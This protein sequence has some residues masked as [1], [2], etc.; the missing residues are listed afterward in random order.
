MTAMTL[1]ALAG[2][3]AIG[4][5]CWVMMPE[6]HA[7]ARTTL[8]GLVIALSLASVV[9]GMRLARRVLH[10]LADVSQ[11]AR[12]MAAGDLTVRAQ[13]ASNDEIGKL[14]EAANG[15]NQSLHAM[16]TQ[17][18]AK[19]AKLAVASEELSSVSYQMSSTAEET[20]S[21][22]SAV[23][24]GAEQVSRSVETAAGAVEEMGMSILEISKSTSEAARVASLAAQEAENTNHTV[25]K[26]GAS[27][28]EIGNVVKV[29]NSIAQQTNLLALNATIEAARAGEAG[30][31]FAVVANEVKDLAKGTAAATTDIS[32]KIEMIQADTREAI[33][34]IGQISQT[35]QQIKDISNTI[36][37]AIDE[38]LT[39]T[40][41]IGRNLGEAARG[42]S[43]IT[44]GIQ[45]VAQAARDTAAGSG[46]TQ[47]AAGELAR[48]AGDLR[49]LT[50]RFRL[51]LSH[52]RRGR[53]MHEPRWDADAA[54]DN[55]QEAA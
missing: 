17:L 19:G 5:I 51:D 6:G 15:L 39:T 12:A 40:A 24:V 20:S 49:H 34:A 41:E 38:Q 8:V 44:M 47:K 43:E 31:G 37:S 10:A 35:I 54:D 7:A 13:V 18:G 45:N 23:S 26:L 46:N 32:R 48:M 28:L 27:S 9:V 11:V 52:G 22:A 16:V 1:L 33:L 36:A 42:S 25:S 2:Y 30:K 50:A 53:S 14:A 3:A 21:Q 4:G 29:I 55:L